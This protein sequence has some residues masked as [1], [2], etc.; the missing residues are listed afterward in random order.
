[1]VALLIAAALAAGP[2]TRPTTPSELRAACKL[3]APAG[4]TIILDRN[5]IGLAESLYIATL[6]DV[7]ILGT[8]GTAG[9]SWS[10]PWDG[11]RS[12]HN[13]LEISAR[14]IVINGIRLRNYQQPGAAL[15]LDPT[16]SAIVSACTIDSCGT[17]RHPA[18]TLPARS[19]SDVPYTSGIAMHRGTAASLMVSG[20]T[21]VNSCTQWRDWSHCLYADAGSV[22]VIGCTYVASG[23][24]WSW[25]PTGRQATVIGC[26]VLSTCHT[27]DRAGNETWPYLCDLP[28]GPDI[29]LAGNTI[30]G[31]WVVMYTGHPSQARQAI[32]PN[33]YSGAI[34]TEHWGA[35]TGRGE[36]L[37][38]AQCE[39]LGWR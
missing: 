23:N 7:T 36:W 14:R 31:T 6:G 21:W 10:W 16:E 25:G 18:Y 33:D 28:I 2:T 17:A 9:L 30:A 29:T 35:D 15:K 38:R 34:V 3:V 26:R 1:M 27:R 37:T 20:C 12:E 11:V 22:T 19:A 24:P 4:G 13:G 8:T 32:G 39:A 5:I